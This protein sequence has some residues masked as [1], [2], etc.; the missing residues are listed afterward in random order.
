MLKRATIVWD[1]ERHPI[2]EQAIAE[3]GIDNIA[4]YLR[5]CVEHFET[6]TCEVGELEEPSGPHFQEI[7]DALET[8]KI[9]LHDGT[10]VVPDTADTDE[11]QVNLLSQLI[12]QV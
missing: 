1:T 6:H 4:A 2:V 9:M 3:S 7:L 12:E 11:D 8:I 10:L 5:A